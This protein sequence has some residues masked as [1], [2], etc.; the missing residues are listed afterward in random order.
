MKKYF[1]QVVSYRGCGDYGPHSQCYVQI[2]DDGAQNIV[3]F[4]D[5]G[6][7]TS[8]TNASEHIAN[9]VRKFLTHPEKTR[10]FETYRSDFNDVDEV[11]YKTTDPYDQPSWKHISD[12]KSLV[13]TA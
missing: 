2:W 3:L 8:V 1:A 6:N 9:V 7:G 10:F 11:S 4:E 13:N 5:L 12:F